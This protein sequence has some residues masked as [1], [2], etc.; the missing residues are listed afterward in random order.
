MKFPY[1]R[2]STRL[3]PSTWRRIATSTLRTTDDAY[4]SA[5][6]NEGWGPVKVRVKC[7]RVPD[8]PISTGFPRTNG[9]AYLFRRDT[10]RVSGLRPCEE[11][12]HRNVGSR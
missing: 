12:E 11:Q 1:E 7:L 3:G 5:I 8:S 10:F 6:C 2:R 9:K 4:L